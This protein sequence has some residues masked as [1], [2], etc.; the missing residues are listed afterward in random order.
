M[1]PPNL[2][3]QR[4]AYWTRKMD[5]GYAFMEAITRYP[6]EENGEP[7]ASLPEAAKAAGAQV[8]FSDTPIGPDLPRQFVLR[9]G[10]IPAFSAMA[11]A[12]NRRG[13]ILKVEDAYRTRAMQAGLGLKPELLQKIGARLARECGDTPPDAAFISRRVAA[14][15]AHCP[16]TGT[17]MSASALDISVLR[18]GDGSE[19]PRGAPYLE[20]SELTPME[21]PFISPNCQLNRRLI[22]GIM[23]EFGFVEYPF[24]F[25]HY[26][27]G[28]AIAA[29]V[30]KKTAPARYGAVDCHENGRTTPVENPLEPLNSP[31]TLAAALEAAML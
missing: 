17:H 12:M 24:E 2:D 21:S 25:W 23:R 7:L 10:L 1:I 9:Q 15:I 4:R 18:R 13:F 29:L 30:G 26:S 5:E 19:L 27:S 8:V 28:D 31:E 14:L 3:R 20:M 6:V 22:T 11:K 16:K